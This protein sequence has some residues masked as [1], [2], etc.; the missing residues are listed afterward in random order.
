[1]F[2]LA[3]RGHDLSGVQTPEDLAEKAAAQ[4]IHN[5]QLALGAS[6]PN[7]DSSAQA[8]N[9]GMGTYFK[10][11]LAKKDLQVAILSCYSNLIHPDPAS[12]EEILQRFEAYLAHARFFGASMVASET[13]SVIPG[14]GYTE[15]NFQDE[16]FEDLIGVVKRLVAKGE[17]MG[18]L[19]GIEGGLNHPLYSLNRIDQLLAAIDSEYL[20]IILDP[21]NL[22]TPEN[23]E[24]QV[25][26][27]KDAF[28]RFGDKICAFHL[29]DFVIE[30]G[31]VQPV[32]FG[33]GLM[34]TQAILDIIAS[35]K[36]YCY[37]V[38]EGTQ[39]DAI[40]RAVKAI[41]G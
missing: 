6:F 34:N 27:V 31:K 23:Y 39:N 18:T 14:L 19:V 32:D 24:S 22:I 37:V 17:K 36:P 40:K 1:M 12:R 7:M 10:N 8:I 38:L 20:G 3:I 30:E 28:E 41:N 26:I 9:P 15:D 2:N 16:V 29:K 25:D 13:G 11:T 35:Y 4:E 21:S 33:T 5:L